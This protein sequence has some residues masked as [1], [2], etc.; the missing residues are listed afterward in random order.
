MDMCVN[1]FQPGSG[2]RSASPE[3]R[4]TIT[5]WLENLDPHARVTELE[6]YVRRRCAEVVREN[7]KREEQYSEL[8]RAVDDELASFKAKMNLS[9]DLL[10]NEE[11]SLLWFGRRVLPLYDLVRNARRRLVKAGG[12]AGG[13]REIDFEKRT[14][15]LASVLRRNLEHRF[16]H[17]TDCIDRFV[18]ESPYLTGGAH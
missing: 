14:D 3:T 7:V 11:R 13:D 9:A 10:T 8:R 1:P 17:A 5:T 16:R 18:T 2:Y 6:D 15:A 4:K 12:R